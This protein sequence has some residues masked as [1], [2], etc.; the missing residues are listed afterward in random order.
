MSGEGEGKCGAG[1]VSGSR[2]QFARQ[3]PEKPRLVANGLLFTSFII[4]AAQTP[5]SCSGHVLDGGHE[6]VVTEAARAAPSLWASW[7]RST[8]F[9]ACTRAISA[10]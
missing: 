5:V 1:S 8:R 7:S 6:R 2:S 9:S 10:R 3:T 4:L